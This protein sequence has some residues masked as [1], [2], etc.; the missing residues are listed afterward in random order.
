MTHK[1]IN[2][3][4]YLLIVDDS[5]IK[6]NDWY[7][8]Y[9]SETIG[10]AAPNALGNPNLKKVICH[11]P[12]N[13]SPILE[14]VDLLPPLEDDIDQIIDETLEKL[15]YDCEGDK[16]ADFVDGFVRGYNKAKEKYSENITNWIDSFSNLVRTLNVGERELRMLD[17]FKKYI[18]S[19][20]QPKMPV[21]F[22]CEMVDF[23]V[24]MGLG[25]EC[26]D[27]SQY[28]K[29]TTNSQGITQ[30]IGEYIY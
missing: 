12:L 24:D 11:L 3:G 15:G 21:G 22:K 30:W 1:I 19:L 29:I 23:E 25:E 9:L 17:E 7:Y 16:T 2:T 5:E 8:S 4:D 14:G 18:Q 26:I 6:Y 27:Y 10:Q 20:K 28:P 13:N